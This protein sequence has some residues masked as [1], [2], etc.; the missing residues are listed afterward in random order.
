M[1][2]YSYHHVSGQNNPLMP[3]KA[4]T[5]P[6]TGYSHVNLN[7][8]VDK[9]GFPS[10]RLP[11]SASTARPASTLARPATPQLMLCLSR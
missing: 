8:F 5:S 3:G 1:L 7:A 6:A 9:S 10:S 11:L 4:P 2:T